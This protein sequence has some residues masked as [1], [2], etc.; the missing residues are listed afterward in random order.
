VT[1]LLGDAVHGL[2]HEDGELGA[3]LVRVEIGRF[4]RPAETRRRVSGLS[5]IH[6][7]RNDVICALLAGAKIGVR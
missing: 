5:L 4:H 6:D 2:E 7:Q 3:N 1:R